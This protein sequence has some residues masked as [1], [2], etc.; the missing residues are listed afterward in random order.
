MDRQPAWQS[1]APAGGDAG[2]RE[3]CR[4][5]RV[6]PALWGWGSCRPQGSAVLRGE[7]HSP[8]GLGNTW[9]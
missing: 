6:D 5:F 1:A 8:W 7:M 9:A 4:H 3:T 2:H